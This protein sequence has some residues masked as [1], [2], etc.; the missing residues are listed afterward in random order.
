MRLDSISQTA[1]WNAP[2]GFSSLDLLENQLA[3][4]VLLLKIEMPDRL[5]L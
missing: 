2:S 1:G 3:W 5:K 4:W